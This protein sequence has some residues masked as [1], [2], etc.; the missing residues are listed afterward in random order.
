MQPARGILSCS[1]CRQR[2]LKCN[3]DEPCSNC[4]TRNVSCVY[5]PWPRGRA[6]V[7]QRRDAVQVNQQLDARVRQLEQLLGNIVSQ[8]PSE[9]RAANSQTSGDFAG[10]EDTLPSGTS[11]QHLTSGSSPSGELEVKPG[12]MVSSNTEMIYVSGS[13]WT[14]ICT[15]VEKIREHLDRGEATA[16]VDDQDQSQSD[17][18]MLL[19]GVG[20]ISNIE[21]IMAD[22]PPKDAVDRLVSR[23]FNSTE[24]ST[25]VFHAPTFEKEYKQFWLDPKGASLQWV[26]ILF[27]VM[28]MGTFLY[29]RVQDDLPGD[30]GNPKDLMELFHRRS[31]ECL[32]LSKYSTAPGIYSLEALLFNIQ[33]EFIRR[34]DAHLG[35]WIL[36]GVAIRLAMRMGYH[37]DP[38]KH[39]RIT[40][41]QGEMRRR[42][43]A[44]V[45][46]LDILTSCQLGLPCLIQE[47]QCDTRPPSN[48]LDDDFGPHS[49]QL[50]PPRPETQMTPVLYT[51]TKVKLSSIFRTIFNQ[52]S[53]GRTEA[54]DEIMA[55]DQRLHSAQR[56]MPPKFHMANPEDSITVAPYILIRRYNM[57]LL[58]QKSRCMLHR[59][60]MAKAY[61]DP[62][63]NYSRTSCVEAAM[64]LL[65][66]QANISKEI[67]VGGR[68]YRDRWF[69]SSLER[70]DFSLAS[71]IICLELSSRSN[72]QSNPPAPDDQQGFLKFSREAMVEALESSRRFWEA[73]KVGSNEARQAFDMLSVML[74]K[75]STNPS[76]QENPQLPTPMD[77]NEALQAQI[78][79]GDIDNWCIRL[80]KLCEYPEGAIPNTIT[81][82]AV[83][84][85]LRHLEQLLNVNSISPPEASR[86]PALDFFPSIQG[87]TNN[88]PLPFFLDNDLFAPIRENALAQ[89]TQSSLPQICSEYHGHDPMESVSTY[90]STVHTWL[91]MIS[92]KRLVF[93]LNAQSPDDAC[94]MLL[95]LCIKLCITNTEHQPKELPL[96]AVARSFCSAAETGGFV[97]LRL[98]QSLV[99]L[100]VYELSHAIYPAA[101]L[102]L[103]RAARLGMLM[104]FHDRK[105]AQQLFKPADTWTLREEQRRTW[106]AIFILDRFVNIDSSLPPA[107]P[108]PCQ[109]E[110]LPVNDIDWDNGTVVPSE[111][112]YTQTFSSVTTVGSF[113]KTCQAA[114]MLSKVMRH[115]KARA[116]SQDITELLPEAQHLHQAL[117]AL[118]LSIEGSESDGASSQTPESS[119][120]PALALCCSARLVLY[121]Q[122]ACNEPLGLSTNGPIALETE[123][124]KVGLE[125]IRAIASS[126]ARLVA[127]DAG[128]CPFVARFLYHAGTECAWFIKENHEQIMYG[129]L[130]DILGGL[131]SMSEHWGLASQYIS[132]LEQEEVLKLIDQDGDASSSTSTF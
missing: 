128:G 61:Q 33:G 132:L 106:W 41:F 63:Y 23:Y 34:R 36:G 74:D 53:L 98:L 3:R 89:S 44:L 46:Q 13:H 12:R 121:N 39:S 54:Y 21:T 43:W 93:E 40:P 118:H 73:F 87:P 91:P 129:A 64:A 86:S 17:G 117:S 101:F 100:A 57:E 114:H 83:D 52:V 102:T 58:F 94:L 76:V 112:L 80:H 50:P 97:S 42:T 81:H 130:E 70:H 65:T 14:A 24:P 71:M 99:L 115:A 88:F 119:T 15:E 103:G 6:P 60:H 48:L 30:L 19:E 16:R 22:I 45:L 95:V 109:S 120:F 2:K 55:L 126:T 26:A 49:A 67:Q 56:A 82:T 51:I 47:H 127:L 4:V 75:V 20:Q 122:Y 78:S 77:I 18:P 59:H 35:V 62:A 66:H 96:Y 27:G 92:R 68:L 8:M 9:R 79:N 37:R 105:A 84:D 72:E 25:I 11:S 31:T 104:G 32:L 111:P 7:A 28:E 113:A 116:S 131:R 123:L 38:D 107:T 29:M 10:S 85:R 125:G 110:L 5:P 1:S 108:E 124:Q 90:F 69:V